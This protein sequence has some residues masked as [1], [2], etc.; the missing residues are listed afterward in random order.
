MSRLALNASSL[1][2]MAW[3]CDAALA[4]AAAFCAH[5]CVPPEN[6]VNAILVRSKSDL[7]KVT[8][9]MV[10]ATHRLDINHTFRKQP[11]EKKVSFSPLDDTRTVTGME[12]G[13]VTLISLYL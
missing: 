1:P 5:Y 6:S 9:C 4:D 8:L 2:F 7:K 3:P 11:A 12:I 10:L 13:G